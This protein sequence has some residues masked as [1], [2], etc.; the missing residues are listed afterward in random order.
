[1][2]SDGRARPAERGSWLE[3]ECRSRE[4][5]VDRPRCSLEVDMYP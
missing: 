2:D 1:M 5:G 4:G 3:Q